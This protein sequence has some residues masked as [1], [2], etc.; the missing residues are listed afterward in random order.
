MESLTVHPAARVRGT[1]DLPGDKSISHR[2]LMLGAVARGTTTI[3]RC[4]DA[5]DCR[6]TAAAFTAM[7]V[8]IDWQGDAVRVE[9][10]GLRG[11]APPARPIDCGNSGTSMRLL[12]GLL[13]GQPFSATLVGDAS[14]SRRPMARVTHPLRRMGAAIDG[15]DDGNRAPLTVRGGRL[16]GLT[17]TMPIASAQVKSALLLAG[18]SAEGATVITE[19]VLTRDHTERLLAAM[20]ATISVIGDPTDGRTITLHGGQA[21]T[22]R[23]LAIPGDLSSAAFWLTAAALVPGSSVTVRD[24]GLNPTRT[25]LLEILR[26]M[27]A[28]ITVAPAPDDGWEPRGAVTVEAG[29][30]RGI[31][32]DGPI[33]PTV[34]DELPIVMIAAAA[35]QGRTVIAG[36]GELRAK[37]TDR[38]QSM[39]TNLQALGARATVDGD[40]MTIEGPTRF[41]G[42]RVASFGDHRTAMACSIPAVAADG[43][44]TIDDTACLRTSYPA[45]AAT[46]QAL[47]KKH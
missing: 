22:G 35:A 23:P 39:G 41:R 34:I 8:S 33:I 9:G 18:L 46:L 7:G 31:T 16:T 3:T 44:V 25:G 32:I 11:L 42:G 19:P 14:L 40:T 27:G 1:V 2:A 10:R 36:A 4:L 21:L 13:A 15:A 28:A 38:L 26:A 29:P 43:P 6:A 30:L 20:G 47:A 12:L 5:E 17:Y 37:E 45:F 24:V